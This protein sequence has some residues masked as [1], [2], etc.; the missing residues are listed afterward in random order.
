MELKTD[1]LKKIE[2][3]QS[4]LE[5]I[6]KGDI[7]EI[8]HV[9]SADQDDKGLVLY[10][11]RDKTGVRLIAVRKSEVEINVSSYL[12]A[13][14]GNPLK[15]MVIRD[16]ISTNYSKGSGSQEYIEYDRQLKMVGL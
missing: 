8:I 9:E 4:S 3:G 10:A 12:V 1:N 14:K 16:S 13:P 5:G 11:D 2:K 7:V 6:V 15:E